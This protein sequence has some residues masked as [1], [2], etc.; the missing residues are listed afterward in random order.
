MH[1]RAFFS[2]LGLGIGGGVAVTLI[3]CGTDAEPADPDVGIDGSPGLPDA[4]APDA[5]APPDACTERFVHLHDTNA[6]ALYLDDTLG[7]LTGIIRVDDVVAG[8]ALTL[9]FWHGHG[10][11]RHRFTLEPTH[12]DALKRG[13]RITVGTTLV[14][15]HAHTL[16][17]DPVDETYRVPGAPDVPV[18]L[19]CA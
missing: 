12:F 18:S 15:G 8:T 19:G 6:Q 3:S 13:E 7:P 17:I 14:D 1:R 10:G 9:D 5:G 2:F 16:F 4:G 11:V